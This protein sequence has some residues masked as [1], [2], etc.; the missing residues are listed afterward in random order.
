M[1]DATRTTRFRFWL[2]LI[3]LVGVIVPR[4]LRANWRRE[5]EA[6]LRHREELLAQWDRL[7]WRSKLDLLRR[8]TSAFWDALWLQPKRWEDEMIQ[9]LRYG[10]RML[11][12]H[13]GMTF[14]AVITLALGIGANTAIFSVVNGVLLSPL[15]YRDPQRLVM[16]WGTKP[17]YLVNAINSAEFVELRD[18]NQSF[19]H[20]AA[21]QPLTLNITQGGE[22]EVIGGTRASAN[23]F[24]LLGV[25][26][27]LGRT[28]HPEEDQP[29]ANRVVILSHGLWQRRFG[30]DPKIVGQTIALNNEPYTVVGVAPPGFQFPRKGD[31]PVEW[32]YSDAIDFYTP[33]AFTPEQIA[34]RR[35]SLAV[36]ARLKPQFSIQQAH[37]EMT[38]FAE[39]LKQQYPDAYRD[40]GMRVVELRQHV[41]GGVRLAL[42]VLQVAVGFVLLIACANVA[43]LL[44]VRAAARQKEMAIRAAMG[45]GRGRVIRQLLTES[46]LLAILSGALALLMSFWIVNLLRK[47]LPDNLPRAD[48]IGIDGHV[49]GFMF[50]ISL[51]AGALFGLVPALQSSRLNLS[52]TLKEG[53]RSHGGISSQ[54]IRS[55]LVVSEVALA[56][57]LLIG[58]GLMV[59]SF[60][61]LISVDPGIDTQNVLTMDI[62]LPR[63]KYDQPQRTAFFQQLHE[64]L[65]SLP[66]VQSVG[67]VYPLPLSGTD[68]G[69]GL[70]LEGLPPADPGHQRIAGPRIVGGDYFNALQIQVKAGRVFTGG[71][72]RDTPPVVVINEAMAREYWPNQNPVGKRVSFDSRDGR[73]LWREIVGIVGDVRHLGLDRGLRP[74]IY[75]PFI[76]FG[77]PPSTL[78]AR[79]NGAPRSLIAAIR[80]EVQAIDKDQPISNIHTLDELLDK[81]VAQRRF[82]LW[83]LGIFASV[84]LALAAMGIYGVMSY[85]VAQRKH[86]IGVRMALGAQPRDVLK[87]VVGRGLRLVLVGLGVGLVGALALTRL[88]RNLLFEVSATDPL[89]FALIATLLLGV[90]LLACYLP[91]RRATK[92]DPLVALRQE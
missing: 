70:S 37:A 63:S 38:W 12:R 47:T 69:V 80:K 16:V 56:L 78:V 39:R 23:L 18:Q 76:Q 28:F 90:A 49:F 24:T 32:L 33:L 86:E 14:I 7:D 6:E 92:V 87:M 88:L 64:R 68:E 65:R 15:S 30:S 83:S 29:G 57:A 46:L 42:L 77:G 4:R 1:A 35:T 45:A 58:A 60:V 81:S 13:K 55:A 20:V 89:T 59:R 85:L 75:I 74:E 54:R 71:D 26:P 40:K 5:W 82:N 9:D 62:R 53:G 61:R 50:L 73:P 27:K 34:R 19:E 10:A 84:A 43:N 3:R 44:L 79:A 31:M 22:P 41:T 36:I 17:Q 52:D 2:W 67:A 72:G 51:L 25:E 48:E 91:A 66:G 8:S 11:L 21:F